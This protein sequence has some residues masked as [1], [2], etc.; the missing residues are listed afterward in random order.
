[1]TALARTDRTITV[2]TS[3][4]ATEPLAL[5]EVHARP[6]RPHDVRVRVVAIGVNPVDWKMRSGGPLR[7]A[8]RFVG[9]S[10]PL[11]VGVD[12]A[13]E[14]V[15]VGP[16]ADLELGTRVVGGT[17]FSRGQLGSYATEVVVRAD[18]C[19]TLP[20]EVSFEQ[21]ACLPVPGATALRA[22][23][24]AHLA[25]ATPSNARIL[26]L[27]ASGGVG[28]VT[29]QLARAMGV[30]AFGVCS[31]RNVALVERLGAIA[32]DYTKGD[33]L[34]AAREH[35]PFQLV[36]HCVG[37]EVYPL[38]TSRAML[39]PSGVDA[40]AVV[41]PSDA[42]SFL[43]RRSVKSVLG[44]PVRK[45]LEPL[46]RALAKGDVEPMIEGRFPL[47]EAEKAH[48]LSKAGK[49]VGKLLLLP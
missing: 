47:A 27:G 24:V 14:I 45:N 20:D 16:E 18:Q 5:V 43:F 26:V 3:R 30:K 33:A 40:L 48:E 11:V 9:P 12:F 21:A 32:I 35:G 15:E 31:T 10:G 8:H 19:A 46:V 7:L 38:G 28:I 2:A 36:F 17:D 34:A 1:M 23:E 41:R 44:R 37:T 13:G 4:S 49:V 6:L 29:L 25:D 39:T 42:F 22:F